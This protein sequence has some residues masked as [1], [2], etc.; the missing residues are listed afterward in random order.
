[1]LGA[2]LFVARRLH[3]PSALPPLGRAG[4]L[5]AA[6]V[7]AV[8]GWLALYPY[9]DGRIDTL[10]CELGTVE[11]R[12]GGIITSR[13]N[14]EKVAEL[15]AT[16]RAIPSPDVV[17]LP[18]FPLAYLLTDRRNPSPVDW[19]LDSEGG[20][21]ER[22]RAALDAKVRFAVV[23]LKEAEEFRPF[24]G[25]RLRTVEETWR[26]VATGRQFAVYANPLR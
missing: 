5:P 21:T 13:A 18:A 7:A 16:L 26:R 4:W 1:L 17:V 10:R 19:P 20:D 12:F 25:R 23:D 24:E 11:P 3:G 9:R 14:C 8:A 6:G 22:Y 15:A 2:Y